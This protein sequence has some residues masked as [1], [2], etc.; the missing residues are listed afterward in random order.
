[1]FPSRSLPHPSITHH[2]FLFP[3]HPS[4]MTEHQFRH[5]YLNKDNLPPHLSIPNINGRKWLID[6]KIEEWNGPTTDIYSPI[7]NSQGE[8]IKIGDCALLTPKESIRAVQA[9]Q[10]AY[11]KGLGTWPSMT[12][13]ERI[14][15]VQKFLDGLNKLKKQIIE[16]LMWEICKNEADAT[17]EVERTIVYIE[18]SISEL[19]KLENNN[20][21]FIRNSGILAQVRRVPLGVC[22]CLGPFNYPFN[23]TYTV[24]FPALL[25]GNSVIF[26]TPRT[27]CLCH[28]LT[29]S[30]FQECFPPG[31]VNILH[32]SGKETLPTIMNS[33]AIDVFAFIG[34]SQAASEL[35]KV[36]PSPH[37]LRVCLG[38]DA[39]N[40]GIIT[41]EA[42]LNVAIDECVLGSLSYNGQRCTA[43][44]CLYVHQSIADVFVERF[45]AAVDALK[46][47]LPWEKGVSI[48]PLPEP[49]KPSYLRELINDAIAKGARI[50]NKNGGKMDQ[51]IV[52]PT[53]L[54]PVTVGMRV[55]NEEQFGPLVPVMKYNTLSD[56]T[57]SVVNS[58]FGQ[59]ASVFAKNVEGVVEL[60]DL[61]VN[62][63]SRVN[64]NTQCQRGPD[65][66]PFTGRKNSACGTLSVSDALRVMS[67]RSVMATKETQNNRQLLD[68]ILD[69]K[70]SRYL[71]SEYL[72]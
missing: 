37:K 30:L 66:L 22:L 65:V 59:Q 70:K 21:S 50:T 67:I 4:S 16:I 41:A 26:K 54:Y 68:D 44:K 64:I 13:K 48:T 63:V 60:L 45:S 19:K 49:Q 23:E 56:I 36:H 24:L 33:G 39:K 32:G 14:K 3:K 53:V 38:L 6:G 17:K 20:I 40:P 42:D 31:V 58:S 55:F 43:L 25:M 35:Q 62:Q 27:G 47:G 8:R 1:L 28:M 34:T 7:L 57:E 72:L 15:V 18:D 11:G 52:S 46:I 9:A 2:P 51:T 10:N 5:L 69:S 29:L 61:L 71:H 12:V